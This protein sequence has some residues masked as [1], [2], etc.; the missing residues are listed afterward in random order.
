MY[1]I[2]CIHSSIVRYLGCF[3]PLAVTNK[4][5]TNIVE[6]V[7]LW[8]GGASFS[9]MPKSDISEFSHRR[10]ISNVL[11]NLQIDFHKGLPVCNP[12]N[13]GGIYL[14]L[15]IPGSIWCHLSLFYLVHSDWCKVESQGP[16]EV[17]FPDD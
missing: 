12:T 14:F 13:S 16:F 2:F 1:H 17:Y 9:Y 5:T 8:Y 11:R 7:S 15:Y 4:A 6:H 3:Q 10:S